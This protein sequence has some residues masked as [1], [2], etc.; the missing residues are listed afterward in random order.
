MDKI[1]QL[2]MDW[3]ATKPSLD[4]SSMQIVGR[5]IL[6]GENYIE[7]SEAVVRKFGVSYTE[8]DVLATLYRQG[9]PYCLTP[10]KLC[11]SVILTSGAMTNCLDRLENKGLIIRDFDASDRRIRTA[12]LTAHGKTVIEKC[13]KPRFQAADDSVEVLSQQER[14]QLERLLTKL[15]K[16]I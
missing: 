2:I 3:Q 1:S 10:T 5:I 6:L 13:L 9:K 11:Q 12:T 14:N 8:F 15:C 16:H 4:I 7:K